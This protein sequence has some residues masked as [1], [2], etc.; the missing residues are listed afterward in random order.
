M[1]SYNEILDKINAS[2]SS[3]VE[4][5]EVKITGRKI[6]PHPDGLSDEIAAF[7][8]QKGGLIIFGISDDKQI[9]GL[10]HTD[11]K[12]FIQLIGNICHDMIKPA[13]VDFYIDSLNIL[14]EKTSGKNLIYMEIGRSL[15]LHES[16]NGFFLST[17]GQ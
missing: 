12:T 2:E 5:K 6:Q 7:A 10:N 15:W 1:L 9:L 11:S 8:N 4:F 13:L 14:D 16:K 17:C 3:G